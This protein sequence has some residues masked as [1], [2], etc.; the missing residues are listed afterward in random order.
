MKEDAIEFVPFSEL[1]VDDDFFRSLIDDYQ[2]F[3]DW[4][5]RKSGEGEKAYVLRTPEL[6]VFLYWKNETEEDNNI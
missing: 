4:F 5:M 3:E 6:S 1:N 2:G